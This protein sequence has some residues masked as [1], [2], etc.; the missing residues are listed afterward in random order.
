MIAGCNPYSLDRSAI[1]IGYWEVTSFIC[2]PGAN[3]RYLP[4][5]AWYCSIV[6][7][8][9]ASNASATNLASSASTCIVTVESTTWNNITKAAAIHM[10]AVN[11]SVEILFQTSLTD[12][13]YPLYPPVFISR[14]KDITQS[15]DIATNHE[16]INI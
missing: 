4:V 6:S 13:L 2:S 14:Y 9:T 15:T 12:S 5:I 1:N 7:F 8:S 10:A 16:F 11:L 3:P